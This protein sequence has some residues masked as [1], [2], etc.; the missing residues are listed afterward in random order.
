[1][2]NK[3]VVSSFWLSIEVDFMYIINRVLKKE[4]LGYY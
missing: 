4:K 2:L 1:M 3:S